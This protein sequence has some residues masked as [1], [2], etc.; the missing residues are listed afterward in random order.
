MLPL[1]ATGIRF[2][3]PSQ[4]LSLGCRTIL[5]QPDVLQGNL[6]FA[7]HLPH[8]RTER[9]LTVLLTMAQHLCPKSGSG[10]QAQGAF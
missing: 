4:V 5:S 2:N 9:K 1:E 10:H 3:L 6:V 8:H 7:R